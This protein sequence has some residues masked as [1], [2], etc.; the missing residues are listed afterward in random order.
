MKK[1]TFLL[2]ILL[3]L[4]TAVP[5][6]AGETGEAEDLTAD[7]IVKVVDKAGKTGNITD[8]KYT[9]Y[10]ESSSRLHPYVILSSD[11]PVY[12]LYLCFQKMP[13]TYVIQKAGSWFSSIQR[14]VKA[15]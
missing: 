6:S 15:P 4:L 13:D 11:K 12:G 5:V 2:T 3:L 9:T 8:G 7:L 10:W 1:L 14:K